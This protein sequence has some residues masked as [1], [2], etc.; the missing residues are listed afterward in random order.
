VTASNRWPGGPSGGLLVIWLHHSRHRRPARL[1]GPFSR[2]VELAVLVVGVGLVATG[3]VAVFTTRNDAGS[4]ALLAVGTVLVALAIVGDRI[5]TIRYRELEIMLADRHAALAG[6]RV[7]LAFRA[8]TELDSAGK[9]EEATRFREEALEELQ[10]LRSIGMSYAKTRSTMPSGWDRTMRM[11][12]DFTRARHQARMKPPSQEQLG[13]LLRGDEGQRITALAA[14]KELPGLRDFDRVLSII[15][16]WRSPFEQY[17][18]LDIAKD[19]LP[20]LTAEQQDELRRTIQSEGSASVATAAGIAFA[21]RIESALR[22][23]G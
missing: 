20:Q 4:A 1:Q 18:A 7:E 17:H 13:S 8:A 16:D 22:S 23:Q 11:E 5:Q 10:E 9:T 14:M 15:K 2:P 21:D 3:A 6:R 12:G 19:M